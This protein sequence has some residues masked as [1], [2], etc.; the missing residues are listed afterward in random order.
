M[1]KII[2][3]STNARI[4]KTVKDAV[5]KY[6]DSFSVEI[7]NTT[8]SAVNFISFEFPEIKVLDYTSDN[9]DC[10]KLISIIHSDAWLHYGGIIAVCRD[11][12]QVR[13][14]RRIERQ[15]Y[16]FHFKNFGF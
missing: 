14:Y 6:S 13:E 8:E 10:A 9:I 11:S 16:A 15:Q 1:K 4:I 5:K 2:T 12:K 7:A 3:A